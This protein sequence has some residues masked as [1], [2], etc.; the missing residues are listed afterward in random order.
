M[1]FLY[2]RGRVAFRAAEANDEKLFVLL[3]LESNPT[4]PRDR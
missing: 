4:P 1:L 2:G 3:D